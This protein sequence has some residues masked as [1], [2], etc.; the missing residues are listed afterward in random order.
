MLASWQLLS[1]LHCF[2]RCFVGVGSWDDALAQRLPDLQAGHSAVQGALLPRLAASNTGHSQVSAQ[3]QPL[4]H[5][6][7]PKVNI[8]VDYCLELA[9]QHIHGHAEAGV[10]QLAHLRDKHLW[11]FPAMLVLGSLWKPLN[12]KPL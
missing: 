11:H 9:Q 3:L 10:V 5:D 7:S 2:Q 4:N 12:L 8:S 1:T 6:S